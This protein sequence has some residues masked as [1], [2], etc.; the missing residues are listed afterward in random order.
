MDWR[1]RK[2]YIVSFIP[3]AYEMRMGY[4]QLIP[5]IKFHSYKDI[6][7]QNDEMEQ[8][9]VYQIMISVPFEYIDMLEYELRKAERTDFYCYWKEIKRD[10]SKKYLDVFGNPISYRRCELNPHKRCNHCMNC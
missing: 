8:R 10:L 7:K 9:G 6:P 2:Y 4:L 5:K 1:T 3:E